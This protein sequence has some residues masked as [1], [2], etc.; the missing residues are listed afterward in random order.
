MLPVVSSGRGLMRA[1]ETIIRSSTQRLASSQ[2]A[3]WLKL[4][5]SRAIGLTVIAAGFLLVV[6]WAGARVHMLA[7][8]M[9]WSFD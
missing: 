9:L 6:I 3:A 1:L 5:S 7:R 2:M 8:L 4:R